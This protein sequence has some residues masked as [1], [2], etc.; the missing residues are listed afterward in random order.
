MDGVMSEE[1]ASSIRGRSLRPRHNRRPSRYSDSGLGSSIASTSGK[2]AA[3][4]Q[5]ISVS[6]VAGSAI[7]HSSTIESL[8]RLSARASNRIT[9]HILWPLLAKQSL[10][11]FHPIV[12]DCPRRIH[13][14]EI[15]CLRDLEKTLIFM[16]PVSGFPNDVTRG[17]AH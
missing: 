12:K 15:V 10:K 7:T 13:D 2:K 16:A 9:Q 1:P 11:D 6:E 8:P 14:K 4:T 5:P 3:E 17:V